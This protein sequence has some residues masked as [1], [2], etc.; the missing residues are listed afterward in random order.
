M[1]RVKI[2][3]L[4]V[5][6]LMLM[7]SIN[8]A[9]D[10]NTSQ[11]YWIHEDRVKP[12]MVGEYEKITKE[13]VAKCKEHNIQGL[14]WI[15]TSTMDFRYL[16][17]SPISSMADINYDGFDPLQEKMGEEAFSKLFSDMDKCYSKHGDYVIVLDKELTYMPDGI[18][19]TPEG[20]DYRKFYY[21]HTTPENYSNL[22]EKMKAIKDLY[23][24]KGSKSHYRVYTS[25]FGNMGSYL[26]VAIAA[27]DAVSF[28]TQG[29]VNDE[30]LGEDAKPVF[31]D[32]MKYVTKMEA[33]NGSMRPDL[34]YI[35]A[36]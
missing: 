13:L 21:L 34:A 16:Y 10:E 30:L 18:T 11:R 36:Q 20:L 14:N 2:S 29:V 35:P 33:V 6:M 12:S 19:Q 9:Q 28:E 8:N 7:P 23:Q 3:L 24:N 5:C 4:L 26:M 1:K 15:T 25:G 32:I 27:K 31:A 22:K 17:V